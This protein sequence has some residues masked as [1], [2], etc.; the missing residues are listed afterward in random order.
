MTGQDAM[1]DRSQCSG[2]RH[3][4]LAAYSARHGEVPCRCP[5]A[6]EARRLNDKRRREGRPV[7]RLVPAYRVSRR[8]Q[9]L[10]AMGYTTRDLAGLLGW[11]EASVRADRT[12]RDGTIIAARARHVFDLYR[13]HAMVPGPSPRYAAT[14]RHRYGWV[15][16]MGWIDIDDP[17]ERPTRGAQI[18]GPDEEIVRR[19]IA[20]QA[21]TAHKRDRIEAVQRLARQGIGAGTISRRLRMS[22]QRV[23]DILGKDAA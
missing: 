1:I 11:S 18:T 4:T 5:D 15:T 17:T 2:T 3:G 14:V 6:R 10:S 7:A 16:C 23:H 22:G 12:S 21:V 13:R 8:L 9:A 19:L 20:G